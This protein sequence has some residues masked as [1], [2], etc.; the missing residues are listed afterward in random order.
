[1]I[2]AYIQWAKSCLPS[3]LAP[4]GFRSEM[5][6]QKILYVRIEDLMKLTDITLCSPTK[7]N[8][9]SLLTKSTDADYRA[10]ILSQI[11]KRN[12]GQV[13]DGTSQRVR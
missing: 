3:S 10:V 5:I 4:K 9:I 11:L 8:P 7:S 1:M 12:L 2:K 13:D 6:P